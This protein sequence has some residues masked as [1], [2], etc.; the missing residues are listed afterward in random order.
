MAITGNKT[1]KPSGYLSAFRRRLGG[2]RGAVRLEVS[3][4]VTHDFYPCFIRKRAKGHRVMQSDNR[5][6]GPRNKAW[7]ASPNNGVEADIRLDVV[8]NFQHCVFI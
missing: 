7:H 6:A 8:A 4:I 5:S 1:S 3:V 2:V